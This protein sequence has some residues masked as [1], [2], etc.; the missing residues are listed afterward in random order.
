[1][2]EEEKKEIFGNC[3]SPAESLSDAL[4]HIQMMTSPESYPGLSTDIKLTHALAPKNQMAKTLTFTRHEFEDETTEWIETGTNSDFGPQ[5]T[6]WVSEL[7]HQ[8][9]TQ[10][11]DSHNND[12]FEIPY[13]M[14]FR[15]LYYA[16]M[17]KRASRGKFGFEW[18][19]DDESDYSGQN[20]VVET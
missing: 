14:S 2:T 3:P 6:E 12:E 5:N 10:L 1:M 13:S 15:N 16:V 8:N 20:E 7:P 9:K 17:K 11:Q 4:G 18:S 19:T